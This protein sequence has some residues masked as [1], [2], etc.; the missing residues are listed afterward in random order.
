M[1]KYVFAGVFPT[2]D[3]ILH[4]GVRIPQ[5]EDEDDVTNYLRQQVSS[6]MHVIRMIF[7]GLLVPSADAAARTQDTIYRV[8]RLLIRQDP[9]TE[10]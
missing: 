10:A 2:Q 1:I 5:L 9:L 8:C 4:C 7:L 3:S 6:S